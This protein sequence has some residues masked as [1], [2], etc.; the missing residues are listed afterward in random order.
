M[1]R[2]FVPDRHQ[3]EAALTTGTMRIFVDFLGDARLATSVKQ[4]ELEVW[5]HATFLDVVR[6]LAERYPALIGQVLE[7]DGESLM[8]ANILNL[9]G[10]HTIQTSQMDDSPSDGDRITFMS[11]L[12]GG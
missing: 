8:P 5:P 9:N 6:L 2:A 1:V 7:A 10:K 4:T 12:A 11:I 3:P